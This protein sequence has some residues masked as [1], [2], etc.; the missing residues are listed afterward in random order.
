MCPTVLY[1]L[2]TCQNRFHKNITPLLSVLIVAY[3]QGGK[4]VPPYKYFLND[5][6]AKYSI[7]TKV[8]EVIWL[9]LKNELPS[10]FNLL[11]RKNAW[12]KIPLYLKIPFIC[13]QYSEIVIPL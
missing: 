10:I 1:P 2:P 7:V 9:L 4:S 5:F 13:L 6:Y 8:S 11:K 3:L 12:F